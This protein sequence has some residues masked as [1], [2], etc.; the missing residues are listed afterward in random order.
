MP[1]KS[2]GLGT[3]RGG[4]YCEGALRGEYL[5]CPGPLLL[6]YLTWVRTEYLEWVNTDYLGWV[7]TEYL[8]LGEHG[9][10][11]IGST[12]YL[13]WVRTEYLELGEHGLP[14]MGEHGVPAVTS[15]TTIGIASCCS[16]LATG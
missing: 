9:V 11:W 13:G 14:W 15:L 12:E 16:C 3:V 4:G 10:L 2:L 7:S 8:K 1:T 5:F 6:G